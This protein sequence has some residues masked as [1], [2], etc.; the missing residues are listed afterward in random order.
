MLIVNSVTT[1]I[2]PNWV[3]ASNKT[4]QMH[5]AYTLQNIIR[6]NIV[7]NLSITTKLSLPFAHINFV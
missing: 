3:T 2:P 5:K 7:Q 1:K 6:L 4:E